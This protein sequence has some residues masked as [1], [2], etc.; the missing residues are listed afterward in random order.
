LITIISFEN[1]EL[2]V[3]KSF[4]VSGTSTGKNIDAINQITFSKRGK[5]YL[6]LSG[7]KIRLFD[8]ETD[9]LI[10]EIKGDSNPF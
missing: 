9:S 6:V 5:F 2:K 10:R 3:L 8:S 7:E 4:Y 1:N